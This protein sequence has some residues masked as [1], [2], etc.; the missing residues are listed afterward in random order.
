MVA[1]L[2]LAACLL[3]SSVAHATPSLVAI[4]PSGTVAVGDVF[5]VPIQV[6]TNTAVDGAAAYLDFD[7]AVLEVVSISV[8]TAFP[9]N[10]QNRFDNAVGTIDFA[11]GQFSALPTST[12]T[13]AA[14]QIRA[15]AV[16]ATTTVSFHTISPRV[17]DLVFH[18]SSVN[19]S[20]SSVSFAVQAIGAPAS[21]MV[22]P[23]TP[24][25][26]INTTFDVSI[27]V[28]TGSRQADGVAVYLNFNP[29]FVQVVSITAGTRLPVAL[30]S[31][32]D[33]AAGTVDF[34][35]GSFGPYPSGTFVVATVRLRA[36]GVTA[37]TPLQIAGSVPRQSDVTYGGRSFGVTPSPANVT[38]RAADA[39]VSLTLTPPM[40][41]ISGGDSFDIDVQLASGSQEVDGAAA[42]LNFDP[43]VIQVDHITPGPRFGTILVNSFDNT[44]GRIDFAAGDLVTSPSGTFSL[45]TV[46]FRSI[47]ASPSSAITFSSTQARKSDV[48]YGGVSVLAQSTDA[49]VTVTAASAAAILSLLASPNVVRAGDAFDLIVRAASGTQRLDG[50]AAYLDFDPSVLQVLSLSA[51]TALTTTIQS[52][53]DNLTGHVD[54]AAGELSSFPTGA[55]DVVTVHT[56]ALRSVASTTIAVSNVLPR[57]SDLTY[58]GISVLATR[59]G[60]AL[61]IGSSGVV[62]AIAPSPASVFVGQ[63]VDVALQVQAGT[64]AVDGAAAFLDFDPFVFEAQ[65]ITPG[66]TLPAVLLSQIDNVNGHVD[67]AAGTLGT[68]PSGTFTVATVRLRARSASAN[69]A[70]SLSTVDP[71]LSDVT[72]GG[73]SVLGQALGAIVNVRGGN[74]ALVISPASVSTNQG[75]LFDVTV[76]V[77]AGAAFVD[78]AAAFVDFDPTK[79]QAV[80][81]T[82]GGELPDG[83]T[84]R[85]DNSVGELDFAAG[86][87]GG[88]PTGTFTLATIKFRALAQGTTPLVFGSRQPRNTDATYGGASVIGS[89]TG[90]QVS[91]GA[92]LPNPCTCVGDADRNSFVNFS[93]YA[94]VRSNFGHPADVST[95]IGD[96]DCN[97]FI[98]FTDYTAVRGQFGHPCP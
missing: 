21:I 25:V 57:V 90:A 95:L 87:L 92:A 23:A 42:Y 9:T 62:L 29:A 98:N 38:V 31:Q 86:N 56:R 96:A 24:D 46:R 3:A 50:A 18:G 64:R 7:P 11:A 16:S 30:Q 33:N 93:D 52:Q 1:C 19:P 58:A 28:D 81:I 5:E 84:I 76:Q 80:N 59:D 22:L 51:G 41:T 54:F 37:S 70:L 68:L 85:A 65:L 32:F 47:G 49:A 75:T 61:P 67:V 34:A 36:V 4:P 2:L 40:Q 91:V 71:R 73:L 39:A 10:I 66:S 45:A 14:L 48:A 69:T 78:G 13:L 12:F 89:A 44:L 8:G 63:T 26:R 83:L 27:Q 20:L 97:G 94:S 77:Q 6:Q 74:V 60:L 88:Y 17:S 79:L 72:T 53:F 82:G 35:A 43:A 55:F 15:K